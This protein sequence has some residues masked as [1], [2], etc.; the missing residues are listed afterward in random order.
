MTFQHFETNG[1]MERVKTLIDKLKQLS[2]SGAPLESILRTTQMLQA[3]LALLGD[4]RK[5]GNAGKVSVVLPAPT[6]MYVQSKF[7]KPEPEAEKV[8]EILQVDEQELEKELAELKNQEM[9]RATETHF[10]V[11]PENFDPIADV[12]TLAH[13]PHSHNSRKALQSKIE[14][15][16]L[17]E[18]EE[19]NDRLK[20]L[21]TELSQSL[22]STP[23][24]DL[25]KAVGVNDRFL[26]I[27][28]LF[29]KDE[30]MY[31]RSIKAIQGFS[32]YAEADFWI[33]RELKLKLGW[34]ALDQKIV[35]QFDDLVKRRFM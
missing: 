28:E 10:S 9:T 24:K 5:P 3:E 25:R 1:S 4:N 15:P 17:P 23:I 35:R 20:Q 2:D 31:E 14:Y 27:N 6:H 7:Q 30:T 33:R 18:H 26:F 16:D 19:L 29:R 8:F 12:P 13:Q 11:Q 34:S 22:S 21:H 32:I